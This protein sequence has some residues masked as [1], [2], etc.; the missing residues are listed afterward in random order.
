M[1]NGSI[2]FGLVGLPFW[3]GLIAGGVMVVAGLAMC[4][5]WMLNRLAG[6]LT[7]KILGAIRRRSQDSIADPMHVSDE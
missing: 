4:F 1:D 7:E 5:A 2:V 3:L 6:V